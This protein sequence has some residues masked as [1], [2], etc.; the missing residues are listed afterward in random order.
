MLLAL[1]ETAS[2]HEPILF[3]LRGGVSEN[4]ASLRES[5]G[6]L[7]LSDLAPWLA[8]AGLLLL[9]WYWPL[10]RDA[11]KRTWI[12]VGAAAAVYLAGAVGIDEVFH[13]AGEGAD[14]AADVG[15]VTW[16]VV[17]TA[18]ELCELVGASLMLYAVL[19]YIARRRPAT[20]DFRPA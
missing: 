19:D 4:T 20:I 10:L 12:R 13:K 17:T 16:R 15:V 7:R 5:M 2:L 11:G 9:V 1:S 6:G 18:E 14:P 8:G 3:V